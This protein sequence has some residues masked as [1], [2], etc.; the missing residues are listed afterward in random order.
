MEE[1][2]KELDYSRLH[3]LADKFEEFLDTL[4]KDNPEFELIMFAHDIKNGIC[5]TYSILDKKDERESLIQCIDNCISGAALKGVE[6]NPNE[7][8]IFNA[9]GEYM[10]R[11]CAM[12]PT[13][14]ENFKKEVD[15]IIEYK[16]KKKNEK[17]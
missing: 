6:K 13:L 15:K 3:I 9:L 1:E 10:I 14:Y 17:I 5:G 11:M 12:V 4:P 7:W 8:E 16:N 2:K